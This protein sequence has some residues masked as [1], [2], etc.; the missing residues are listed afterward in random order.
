MNNLGV[1]LVDMQ[2]FFLQHFSSDIRKK[3]IKN[4]I[5]LINYCALNKIPIIVT[6]YKCGG[7]SRGGITKKLRESLQKTHMEKVIK[8][9]N[10]GFTKTDLEQI[11]KKLKIKNLMIIGVN[12]NACVQDTVI[13]AL[14]RGYKVF[15][16]QNLMASRSKTPFKLSH[17]NKK[18]YEK[19]TILVKNLDSLKKL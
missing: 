5:E 2:D 15:T 13:G 1:I 8:L 17:K 7:V 12:A 6:E 14:N 9:N 11:L 10:G 18:W 16:V 19:N 3:L 4:H